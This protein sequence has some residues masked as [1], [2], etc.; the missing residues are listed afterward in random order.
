MLP[1]A[2]R[3]VHRLDD[4]NYLLH[5]EQVALLRADHSASVRNRAAHMDT[6]RAYA[7]RI[8]SHRLPY[9]TPRRNE[10]ATFDPGIFGVNAT[11]AVRLNR[12]AGL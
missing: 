12:K 11:I 4:F 1:L 8:A 3:E 7:M 5:G 6:A 10:P 9:R 2:R